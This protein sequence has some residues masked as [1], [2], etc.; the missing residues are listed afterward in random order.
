M[1][2]FNN[3]EKGPKLV[4]DRIVCSLTNL[5]SW[6]TVSENHYFQVE[7]IFYS[8]RKVKELPLKNCD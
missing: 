1:F 2:Y 8:L 4:K 7:N 3:N 6:Q 5:A